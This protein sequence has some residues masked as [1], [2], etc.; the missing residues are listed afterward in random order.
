MPRKHREIR[1]SLESKG[2]EI[3][4]DRKHLFFVYVDKEGKTTTARTMMSHG[5]SGDDIGDNLL[6][7]M[8]RQVL[9]S[10]SDFLKLIDCP[11]SQEEYDE[12]VT[13]VETDQFSIDTDKKQ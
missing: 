12:K 2:F 10:R 13:K 6:A 1:S 7:R 5:S 11:M 8:A 3:E 4:E 9:L